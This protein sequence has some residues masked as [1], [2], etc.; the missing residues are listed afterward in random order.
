MCKSIQ[1]EAMKYF[2]HIQAGYAVFFTLCALS[3]LRLG[4]GPY[5]HI[6]FMAVL[7]AWLVS[8]VGLFFRKQ[9]AWCGNV[10]SVAFI[11]F[12]LVLNLVASIR[13][14]PGHSDYAQDIIILVTIFVVPVTLILY[15]LWKTRNY[16]DGCE[17]R[18]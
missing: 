15:G 1:G 10:V 8:S 4:K 6:V 12:L 2:K 16:G 7:L 5:F 17:I 13:T 18:N 9:W 11:W 3:I 14:N